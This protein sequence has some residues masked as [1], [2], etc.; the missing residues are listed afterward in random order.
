MEQ[1]DDAQYSPVILGCHQVIVVKLAGNLP[2]SLG[3]AA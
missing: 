3:K 1:Y 2:I